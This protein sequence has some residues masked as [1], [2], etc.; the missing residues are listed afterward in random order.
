M[1]IILLEFQRIASHLLW[2]GNFCNDIG[3]FFT[4]FMWASRE[5]EKILKLLEDVSGNRMFYMNLRPGGFA[6]DIPGDFAERARNLAGY[7]E[8]KISEYPDVLD[9]NPIF[10]ERT[11]GI[12]VLGRDD[13]IDYGVSGPVLRGSGI[14]EDVRKSR[15]YYVYD[16]LKFIVPTRNSGDAYGRY[17]VRY[18]EMHQSISIIR[19]ALDM[20]PQDSNILGAKAKL[21]G[22]DAN[23]DPVTVSRELPRG[24]GMIYMVPGK[25]GP[26][27]IS[28]RSP[29]FS[30]LSALS[31]MC[32]GVKFA[33]IFP[34]LGSL[35]VVL[36]EVDR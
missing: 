23:P 16:R 32:E 3:Q 2:L 24:E 12:G 22:P 11:R 14:N 21:R 26:Y 9:S 13:A 31:K 35:D 25:Q 18:E 10:M 17:R 5:R 7:L 19:Q 6:G 27:R 34:I 30:N 1:R 20:M 28:L 8:Q 4:M 36:G 33:D 29:S 15:P